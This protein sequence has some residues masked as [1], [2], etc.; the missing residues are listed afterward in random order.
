VH[1]EYLDVKERKEPEEEKCIRS[2]RI[3]YFRQEISGHWNVIRGTEV[4]MGTREMRNTK[5]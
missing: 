3:I 5:F 2:R 4:E 1:R